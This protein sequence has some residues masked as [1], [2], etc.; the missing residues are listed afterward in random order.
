MFVK[1]IVGN[2]S[3]KPRDKGR[4]SGRADTVGLV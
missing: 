4:M 2:L 3:R 1:I